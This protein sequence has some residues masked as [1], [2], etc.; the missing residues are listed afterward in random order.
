MEVVSL[1]I[2]E[3]KLITPQRFGDDRGFFTETWNQ[4]RFVDA[5]LDLDFV[6]DNHSFSKDVG[7]LR[8]LHFQSPPFAQDKLVRVV[9]GAVYDVAVDIRKGS[10]TYGQYVG[11]ELTAENGAQLLVPKGFA[12]GFVTLT[13]N[14][15]FLYKV[16]AL[17]SPENDHGIMWNDPDIAVEWPLPENGPQLS[18]KDTTLP[19][20][21][22]IESPFTYEV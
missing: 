5:G 11:A 16:T 3:V 22:D 15:S 2:P 8:G 21:S 13:E 14:T 20:L 1:A 12:H 9:T 17:Y 4:Q 18:G 6:Q 19:R 10:P 7:V